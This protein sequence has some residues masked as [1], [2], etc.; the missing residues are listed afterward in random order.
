MC[1]LL[2]LITFKFLSFICV[3]MYSH[4]CIPLR[5]HSNYPGKVKN[6]R[7]SHNYARKSLKSPGFPSPLTPNT[8]ERGTLVFTS[9]GMIGV[10]AWGG[11]G[12]ERLFITDSHPVVFEIINLLSLMN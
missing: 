1:V 10:L 3:C 12:G 9:A 11:D 4:T 7:S 6:V 2:L 8:G 5:R